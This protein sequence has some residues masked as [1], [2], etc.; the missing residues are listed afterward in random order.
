MIWCLRTLIDHHQ[1]H[2][3]GAHAV[4]RHNVKYPACLQLVGAVGGRRGDAAGV[5]LFHGRGERWV[6]R[7]PVT[8]G[9]REAPRPLG[10]RGRNRQRGGEQR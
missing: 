10:G 5:R 9:Q 7:D 3:D 2:D 4:G 8:L 1:Q 6:G